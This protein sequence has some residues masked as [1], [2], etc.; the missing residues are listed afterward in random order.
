MGFFLKPRLTEK[1]TAGVF[2]GR[3]S[4]SVQAAWPRIF[5]T[6]R[7]FFSARVALVDNEEAAK[8]EFFLAVLASHLE[9]L[10]RIFE[11]ARADRL[12][13][14]ITDVASSPPFCR[15]GDASAREYQRQVLSEYRRAWAEAG[16][17]GRSPPEAVASR[18]GSRLGIGFSGGREA[19]PLSSQTEVLASVL[20][21]FDVSWWRHLVRKYRIQE[22]GRVLRANPARRV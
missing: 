13:G 3:L 22:P 1:E 19:D 18:L 14:H 8:G 6:I 5:E 12:R 2:L 11:P 7:P 21:N 17:S 20:A 10:D 15:R 16:A 4:L 9:N